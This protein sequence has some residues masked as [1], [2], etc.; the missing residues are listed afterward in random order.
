MTS[1]NT[2]TAG[3]YYAIPPLSGSRLEAYNIINNYSGSGTIACVLEGHKHWDTSLVMPC[4]VPI[5]TTTCDKWYMQNEAGLSNR[6]FGTV[7]EQAFDVGIIDK[8]QRKITM[9]RIGGKALDNH[10][11]EC[12]YREFNY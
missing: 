4:G 5:I 12:E 8:T 7:E 6:E 1:S 10:F 9:V 3:E 11:E 2:E